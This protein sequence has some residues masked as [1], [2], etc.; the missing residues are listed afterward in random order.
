MNSA[1]RKPDLERNHRA[2]RV[3][4]QNSQSISRQSKYNMMRPRIP[5]MMRQT[6][7]F[8]YSDQGTLL[9][10]ALAAK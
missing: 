5:P 4:G 8:R 9:F 2:A 3:I 10:A 6:S 7:V 1:E